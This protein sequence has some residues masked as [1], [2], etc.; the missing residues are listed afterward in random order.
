VAQLRRPASR[1]HRCLHQGYRALVS[2]GRNSAES[3]PSRIAKLGHC[4]AALRRLRVR[5]RRNP[6]ACGRILSA[7]GGSNNR[8]PQAQCDHLPR[9]STMLLIQ[10]VTKIKDFSLRCH[11]R[12]EQSSNSAADQPTEITPRS[13]YQRIRG[14]TSAILSF[15]RGHIFATTS[16][17]IVALK[18]HV[19]HPTRSLRQ[20]S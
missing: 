10:F 8:A 6:T 20:W 5:Y 18:L 16:L 4:R 3:D 11:P 14:V 15:R 12:R 1:A 17:R 19:T 2:T 7:H 13:D 9:R